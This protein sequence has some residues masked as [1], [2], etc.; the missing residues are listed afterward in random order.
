M[1]TYKKFYKLI[2]DGLIGPDIIFE[3]Y[4]I[5]LPLFIKQN[6]SHNIMIINNKFEFVINDKIIRSIVLLKSY[7]NHLFLIKMSDDIFGLHKDQIYYAIISNNVYLCNTDD[8]GELKQS[9]NTNFIG[10]I[11]T[12]NS[13]RNIAILRTNELDHVLEL[14]GYH[15]PI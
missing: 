11:H 1:D 14:N 4:D 3:L 15:E 2:K 9:S 10:Y 5:V 7:S 8:D 12:R 6:I 13:W